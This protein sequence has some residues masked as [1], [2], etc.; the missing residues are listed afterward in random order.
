MYFIPTVWI[1]T[2]ANTQAIQPQQDL[3]ALHVLLVC[4]LLR[5]WSLQLLT[6]C[7]QLWQTGLGLEKD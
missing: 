6:S 4:F 3:H 1:T 5:I 7:E 2:S